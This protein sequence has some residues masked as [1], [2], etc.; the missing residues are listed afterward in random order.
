MSC[1]KISILLQSKI[2]TVSEEIIC[3]VCEGDQREVRAG[4]SGLEA[5][6]WK[7]PLGVQIA[8]APSQPPPRLPASLRLHD[9]SDYLSRL[10]PSSLSAHPH[11]LYTHNL[12]HYQSD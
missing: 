12:N 10:L 1:R 4:T 3:R 8:L 11:F 9:S 6:D 2:A 7:V 5:S